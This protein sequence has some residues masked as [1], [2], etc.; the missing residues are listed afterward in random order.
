MD[1]TDDRALL[2]QYADHQS[3]EAF[4][5]LV[6]RHIHLVYSVALRQVGNP[7]QAGEIT[8][9]VF[10]ILAKK[11]RGLR[12]EQALSSWLFQAARWTANNYVRSEIRRQ[13]REQEAYMQSALNQPEDPL[14]QRIAPLLDPAVA[15]LNERDRRTIVLRFYEGRNLC[16]I[17]A[18]LGATEAAAKKRVARALEKLRRYFL[19][20]GVTSTAETLAGAMAAHA[21]HAAPAAL[22][23]TISAVAVAKGAAAGGSTLTLLKTTLKLMAWT[24]AKT[25]AVAGVIVL[26]A[27]GTTTVA[28]KE[29]QDHRIEVWEVPTGSIPIFKYPARPL[30]RIKPSIYSEFK[31]SL[32]EDGLGSLPRPDGS[33]IRTNDHEWTSVGLGQPLETIVRES[34]AADNLHAVFLTPLPA[35]PLYDYISHVPERTGRPLQELL[36]R[37]FGLVGRWEMVETNVLVLKY[38]NPDNPGLQPAESLMHSLNL[39]NLSAFNRFNGVARRTPAGTVHID[40]TMPRLIEALGLERA[41]HLPIIDETGLTNRYDFFFKNPARGFPNQDAWKDALSQQ[42]GLELTPTIRPV[43]MLIVSRAP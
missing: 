2:R 30:V 32:T 25:A 18:A 39:T 15:A 7:H 21:V 17:G 12:S 34:Y 43:R 10:L 5:A 19:K 41:F 27:A 16:E 33:F 3:D 35:Q 8:Q 6:T 28:V 37:K 9:V 29:Y 22:A 4:A 38:A 40:T 20:R 11:A 1:S 13:R 14:W 26:L 24:K 36:Q 42:L 23:T 31:A